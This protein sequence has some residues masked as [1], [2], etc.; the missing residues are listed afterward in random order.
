MQVRRLQIDVA[1]GGVGET[2]TDAI[3]VAVREP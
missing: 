1:E 3:P 2:D